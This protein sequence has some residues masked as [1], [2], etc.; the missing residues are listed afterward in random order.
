MKK[1]MFISLL[2]LIFF[3]L[4]S[5]R[6][7][8]NIYL[9]SSNGASLLGQTNE[10]SLIL[11][12]GVSLNNGR[13]IGKSYDLIYS[14]NEILTFSF[15]LN[16]SEIELI[17]P[18]GALLKTSSSNE[19]YTRENSISIYAEDN[20]TVSYVIEK[21]DYSF[22]I[23]VIILLAI[24]AFTL[25][26]YRKN[27]LS[28]SEKKKIL[29]KVLNEREKLILSQLEKSGKIK[30]SHLRKLTAIPKASLSRHLNM[31]EKKKLIVKSGS[32]KNKFIEVI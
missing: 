32:G 10:S 1:S 31:L 16:D 21:N 12:D 22:F 5:A 17:L 20:L 13:I 27:K 29:M 9:D 14:K 18:E 19:V 11:P 23:Y 7:Y 26:Q 25:I 3:Q 6:N 24:I 28:T 30:I 2:L 4:V 15:S 8:L